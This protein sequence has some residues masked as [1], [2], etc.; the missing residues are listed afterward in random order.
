MASSF[1]CLGGGGELTSSM[2]VVEEVSTTLKGFEVE[3]LCTF[4]RS[5]DGSNEDSDLDVVG[6]C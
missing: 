6:F 5:F 1:I 3:M 4:V 2:F